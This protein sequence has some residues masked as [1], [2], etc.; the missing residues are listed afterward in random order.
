MERQQGVVTTQAVFS[1]GAAFSDSPVVPL[2]P[3]ALSH[4]VHNSAP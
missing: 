3:S 1:G 2:F 4:L